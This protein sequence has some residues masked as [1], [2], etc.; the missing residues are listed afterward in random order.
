[1]ETVT[2]LLAITPNKNSCIFA[3]LFQETFS[4]ET[5]V[6]AICFQTFHCISFGRNLEHPK[7]VAM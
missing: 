7:I 6:S 1:M 5:L 4:M 2:K 3:A